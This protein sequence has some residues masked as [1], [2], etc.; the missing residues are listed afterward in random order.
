M[1]DVVSLGS[2]NVDRTWD[3][4][5]DRLYEFERRYDWF[6]DAGETVRIDDRSRLVALER[7][8]EAEGISPRTVVGGKGTNQA[9]AAARALGEATLLGCV[10]SDESEY[11]VRE[12]LATRGVDVDR[13]AVTDRETGTAFVFV[14]EIGESWIAI[15]GGA[16]DAVDAAYVDRHDDRIRRADALLLQNEIP[17]AT[18]ERVLER[19]ECDPESERPT[20]ICNPAPADGAEPLLDRAVDVVVVNEAEY[21]ALESSL[22]DF[23]GTVVRTQGP[24]DVVVED[25]PLRITPPT[26]EPVDATGAGDAFCG[27]LG[28]LL[29]AGATLERALEVATVAG[30]LTTET[31]GVGNA[32]PSRKRVRDALENR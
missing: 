27:Y 19:L 22:A 20:I 4:S 13:V 14:D 8:L 18:A 9:V 15:V 5:S 31:A 16:N 28:A 7:D 21:A 24:D 23:E 3:L 26:V 32:I 10:G 6:P 11:G 25:R 1:T 2:V 30:S 12:T 29:A 17:A